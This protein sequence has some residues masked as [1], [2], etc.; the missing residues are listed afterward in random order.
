VDLRRLQQVFTERFGGR[1]DGVVC[2]PGRVNLIGEHTD[3]NQGF[4]LPMAIDRA[5]WIA[6]RPRNDRRV[7]LWSLDCEAP[8]ELDLDL[9]TTAHPA[10]SAAA[11]QGWTAYVA[12]VAWSL[13]R[14][15]HRLR[16]FEGVA[17]SDVPLDAGLSS[18]AAL[19]MAVARIFA[20]LSHLPWDPIAMAQIARRAETE[21]V[22]VECGVMDQLTAGCGVQDHALLIDC[23]SLAIEPVPLPPDVAVIVLDTGVRRRLADSAYNLRR[24][25]CDGAARYLGVTTLRDLE[26][27]R[28]ARMRGLLRER[29]YNRA[30]HVLTENERALHVARALRAGEPAVCGRFMLASHRSLA[31]DF[32]VSCP[33]LDVMVRCATR[34]PA[35]YGARMTGAGFGGCVVALAEA[36]AV[37]HCLAGALATYQAETGRA[38]RGWVC[39]AAP[40]TSVAGELLGL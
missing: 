9:F 6:A 19:E 34:Q 12:G 17:G 27:E 8:A 36:A 16:G 7:V 35:C 5:L 13:T 31:E 30:L 18:S 22:G 14:A 1:P 40:G 37:E 4:V 11:R 32:A 20:V 10:P 15:G 23:R 21:W 38:A 2:S 33:E 24:R 39:R 28:L 3:Y 25:E 29:F 26:P